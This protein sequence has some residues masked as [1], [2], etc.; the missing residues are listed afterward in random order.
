ML[1]VVAKVVAAHD[2]SPGVAPT[3]SLRGSVETRKLAADGRDIKP[4]LSHRLAAAL[5]VAMLDEW[6][7]EDRDRIAGEAYVARV[8]SKPSDRSRA[9]IRRDREARLATDQPTH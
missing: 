7:A 6:T 3:R 4:A 9:Q 8:F 2:G 1:G 5:N